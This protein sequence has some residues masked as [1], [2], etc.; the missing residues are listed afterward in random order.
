MVSNILYEIHDHQ[1]GTPN[2]DRV[3]DVKIDSIGYSI[4][5]E[6][7]IGQGGSDKQIKVNKED[8]VSNTYVGTDK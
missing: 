4:N 1:T 2:D 8:E 3:H 5:L 7:I 6:G